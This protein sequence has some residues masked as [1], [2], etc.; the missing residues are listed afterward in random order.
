[1]SRVERRDSREVRKKVRVFA[2]RLVTVIRL[3]PKPTDDDDGDDI[4]VQHRFPVYAGK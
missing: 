1:M 2:N 4:V 3:N